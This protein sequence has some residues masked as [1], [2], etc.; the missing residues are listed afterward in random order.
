MSIAHKLMDVCL[1]LLAIHWVLMFLAEHSHRRYQRRNWRVG[2]H[3]RACQRSE[4][5]RSTLPSV[6]RRQG[7]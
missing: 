3:S 1:W 4:D 5:W 7:E 2:L 6:I